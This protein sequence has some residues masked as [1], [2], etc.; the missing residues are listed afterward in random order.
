MGRQMPSTA[1]TYKQDYGNR[2]LLGNLAVWA[3]GKKVMWDP[4]NLR[5]TNALELMAI[6]KPTY[7]NGYSL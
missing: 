7:H 3:D 4:K 1:V 2:M 6:V 5:P